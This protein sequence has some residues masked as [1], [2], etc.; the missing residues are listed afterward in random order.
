[1]ACARAQADAAE[2]P[3]GRGAEDRLPP[4]AKASPRARDRVMAE[5]ARP[6]VVVVHYHEISLKRGNRPLFLRRLQ[7]SLLR[8]L[9]DLGAV[10]AEQLTGRLLLHLDTAVDAGALAGPIARGFVR[11]PTG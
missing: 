2:A 10:R 3:Q 1:C 8:A 7:E 9:G 11:R 4:P 6:R 5:T